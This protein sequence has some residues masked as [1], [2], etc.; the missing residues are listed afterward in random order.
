MYIFNKWSNFQSYYLKMAKVVLHILHLCILQML[1][2]KATYSELRLYIFYTIYSAHVWLM[3]PNKWK[4]LYV[5]EC[6]MC[7]LYVLC[8]L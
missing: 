5:S 6:Q 2:S 7:K 1:L 8:K 3:R 4:L